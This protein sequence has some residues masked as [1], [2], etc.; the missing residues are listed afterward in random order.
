M[1]YSQ[2]GEQA[3]I[4]E[5]FAGAEPG[6]FLD[7]GAYD[8]LTHSNTRALS[9]RG[10][11]G[12]C[13]EACPATFTRLVENHRGNDKI[14]CVN[15]AVLDYNGLAKFYDCLSP[16]STA[17]P[18]HH[19]AEHVRREYH[20]GAVTVARLRNALAFWAPW[21]FV[22]IDIEGVDLVVLTAS[23]DDLLRGT[24]LVCVEDTIPG[25]AFDDVYYDRLR[26]VLARLGFTKLIGRTRSPEK[27]A[28]TLLARP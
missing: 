25:C 23:G 24:K 3:L 13:V 5:Y 18:G 12:V 8:G 16:C 6:A 17:Y 26:A 2:H 10:W 14:Q 19:V 11:R 4:L 27:P 15:A 1:D 21:D 9:D 28:N 7:L 20:V 22:S